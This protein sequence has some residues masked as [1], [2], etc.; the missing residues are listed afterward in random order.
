MRSSDWAALDPFPFLTLRFALVA[1]ITA[2][3]RFVP[4]LHAIARPSFVKLSKWRALLLAGR[5]IVA[6]RPATKASLVSLIDNTDACSP[7][8]E[9][10]VHSPRP[11][12]AS[13]D[14]CIPSHRHSQRRRGSSTVTVA[15]DARPVTA[16][17][18]VL[19]RDCLD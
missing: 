5:V 19:C 14:A 1:K 3:L 10:S 6:E 4:T 16:A 2:L 8:T 11:P 15:H 7:P 9:P 12:P 13:S 18:T 17:F